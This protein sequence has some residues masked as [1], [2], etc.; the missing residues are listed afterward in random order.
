M[1]TAYISNYTI[2]FF[3]CIVYNNNKKN[4]NYNKNIYKN[5]VKVIIYIHTH[6]FVC[7]A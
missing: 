5:K 3:T 2:L 4:I 6:Y 1:C 7:T